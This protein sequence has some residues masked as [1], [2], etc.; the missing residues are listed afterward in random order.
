M[1]LLSRIIWL[2]PDF[3]FDFFIV[4]WIQNNLYLWTVYFGH[5]RRINTQYSVLRKPNKATV[6]ICGFC[7]VW[8]MFSQ[9]VELDSSWV[10]NFM[11][12][13]KLLFQIHVFIFDYSYFNEV[14]IWHHFKVWSLRIVN[15]EFRFQFIWCN[16]IVSIIWCM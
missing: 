4:L 11:Y 9:M 6:A 5:H 7:T 15:Q 8:H 16:Y 3:L 14:N 10:L 12:F 1:T 2:H 13:K